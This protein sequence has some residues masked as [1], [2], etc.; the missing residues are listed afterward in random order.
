MAVYSVV[1]FLIKGMFDQ[2][3]LNFINVFFKTKISG[4]IKEFSFCGVAKDW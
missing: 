3:F 2:L 4:P 1:K